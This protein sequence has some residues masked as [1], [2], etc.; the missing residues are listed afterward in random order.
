M[1]LDDLTYDIILFFILAFSVVGLA[2]I[3]LSRSSKRKEDGMIILLVS[4]AVFVLFF[5]LVP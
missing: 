2:I 5:K 1:P 4:L 3:F